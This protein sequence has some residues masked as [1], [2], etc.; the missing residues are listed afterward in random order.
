[1]RKSITDMQRCVPFW[2]SLRDTTQPMKHFHPTLRMENMVYVKVNCRMLGTQWHCPTMCDQPLHVSL[3]TNILSK[4]GVSMYSTYCTWI[5]P[6]KAWGRAIKLAVIALRPKFQLELQVVT[7][8]IF[9]LCNQ[10]IVNCHPVYLWLMSHV[11]LY[12]KYCIKSVTL[13]PKANCCRFWILLHT[14]TERNQE[15]RR[16]MTKYLNSIK[17][18]SSLWKQRYRIKWDF[19]WGCGFCRCIGQFRIFVSDGFVGATHYI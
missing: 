19:P 11:L 9:E 3:Y 15:I 10:C 5:L 2:V 14:L 18:P 7:L 12:M 16:W 13:K 6:F 8:W 4:A 17:N 1:M